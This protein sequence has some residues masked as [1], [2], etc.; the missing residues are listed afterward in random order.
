MGKVKKCIDTSARWLDCG[1]PDA[2]RR[3]FSQYSNLALKRYEWRNLPEGLESKYIEQA[4]YKHGQ[5]FFTADKLKGAGLIALPCSSDGNYD[6]YGEPTTL[7]VTGY[8]YTKTYPIKSGVRILDN[9]MIYPMVNHVYHYV[10]KLE[11]LEY[12]IERNIQQQN[13]PYIFSTT[14]QTEFSIKN[15]FNKIKNREEAIYLDKNFTNGGEVGLL[16]TDI[17]KP[18]TV[19]KYRQEYYELE[20][21]LLTLLGINCIFNKEGGM[22]TTELNSNNMLIDMYLEDGLKNR[23]KAA[24][25]INKK[26]GL[27][28]EVVSTAREMEAMMQEKQLEAENKLMQMSRGDENERS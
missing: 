17:S 12:A 16:T 13:H 15:I 26:F 14:K 21:E 7:L 10:K 11:D 19:D 5:V 4:L 22:S 8:G 24:E 20:K 18:Y 2:F 6:I 28:I 27:N 25:E 23:Q 1:Q 3:L 9:W